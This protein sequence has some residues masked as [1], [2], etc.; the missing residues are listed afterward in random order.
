VWARLARYWASRREEARRRERASRELDRLFDERPDVLREGRLRAR[1]RRRLVI[2]EIEEDEGRIS[3]LRVG[4]VR[5]P[6]AHPMQPRGEEVLEILDYHVEPPRIEVV[7]SRN[8][9]RRG[10]RP[11]EE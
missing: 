7:G 8:L 4:I 9:T 5:H 2:L 11:D 1:H 10:A 3:R 6:K